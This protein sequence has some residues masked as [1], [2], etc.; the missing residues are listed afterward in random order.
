MIAVGNEE[1]HHARS[2]HGGASLLSGGRT[3]IEAGLVCED[4]V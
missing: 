2:G 3:A 4:E 1:R